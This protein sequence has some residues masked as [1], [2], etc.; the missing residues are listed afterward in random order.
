M[1]SCH[2]GE[3][4]MALQDEISERLGSRNLPAVQKVLLS[5]AESA[6]KEFGDA[7]DTLQKVLVAVGVCVR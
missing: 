7:H 1:I 5:D 3:T 6:L 4:L 2:A